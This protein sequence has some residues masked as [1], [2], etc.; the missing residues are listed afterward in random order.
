[1]REEATNV[2]YFRSELKAIFSKIHLI[3]FLDY[4]TI[5]AKGYMFFVVVFLFST[6]HLSFKNKHE[7]ILNGNQM[8]YS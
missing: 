7:C 6:S 4:S 1:M 5:S 2:F 8:K 3:F